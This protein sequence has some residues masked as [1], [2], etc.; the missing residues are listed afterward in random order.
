MRA[1]SRGLIAF[2]LFYSA[3]GGVLA[4][5]GTGIVHDSDSDLELIQ[6]YLQQH[7][8]ETFRR[9]N[10]LLQYPYL[11]PSGPYEQC[12]D[13]DSVFTGVGLLGLGGA[14]YLAGSMKNFFHMTN[15]STGDVTQCLDPTTAAPSCSSS[16]ESEAVGAHAKPLLIQG[17]LFAARYLGDFDQFLEFR[18]QMEALLGYWERERIDAAT[19]ALFT[20]HD[21]MESG[22]DNMPTSAC[23]T[24]RSACW[25]ESTDANTLASADVA[26][27]M[28]RE[29]RAF[30]E[31]LD[32]WGATAA[33]PE[34][35]AA[36][37]MRTEMRTEAA[38]HRRRAT[39]IA[40]AIN[41][42]LWAADDEQFVAINT[43]TRALISNAVYLAGVPLWAGKG[44][45]TEQ[46][47]A[48]AAARVMQPDLFSDW[49]V[50]STSSLDP[51]YEKR[52]RCRLSCFFLLSVFFF[53]GKF[54]FFGRR[55]G[56]GAGQCIT[57]RGHTRTPARILCACFP[58][59]C[60]PSSGETS[61]RAMA[62][63]C[64]DEEAR[65]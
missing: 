63:R 54:S 37:K 12:W 13:W 32:H 28:A 46:R 43:T 14:P 19:G 35:A 51:W 15:V 31:F 29:H 57:D 21:Q 20:W 6:A 1:A 27:Q 52:W 38:T 11:V 22:A 4:T 16:N 62:A 44:A 60:L 7:A 41:E 17:A 61:A 3:S 56:G 48:A 18:P 34:A 2:F 58:A 23:P 65:Q 30:A 50:R 59:V 5:A 55:G 25:D 24:V 36:A 8:N 47:A 33:A 10:G 9:A 64:F 26:T 39:Q 49:G 42:H 53:L 40:A 45:M